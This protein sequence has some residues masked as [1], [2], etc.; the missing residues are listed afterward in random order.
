M[1]SLNKNQTFVYQNDET[2]N[3]LRSRNLLTLPSTAVSSAV[4][5]EGS[6]AY[7]PSLAEL[8][9]STGLAWVPISTQG[10]PL[11][12][13]SETVYVNKG[14]NDSTGDGTINAPFLTI[15]HALTTITDSSASKYYAIM[16]GPG[17]Y[18]GFNI[19]PYTAVIGTTGGAGNGTTPN[20]TMVTEINAPADTC[21]FDPSFATGELAIGWLAHLGF[22][23]HQTWDQGTVV[24][25]QPQLTFREI[26]WDAGASFLGPGTVG[27]DNVTWTNC[28]SYG[29]VLVQGWQ[30]LWLRDCTFLGGVVQVNAGPVGAL[31]QTTLL[32]ENTSFGAQISPTAVNVHWA[33]PSPYNAIADLC[34]SSIIGT[35]TLDG[36]Q[37]SFSSTVEGIPLTVSQINS[38]PPPVLKTSAFALGYTPTTPGNWNAP[39]PT[40]TQQALDRMASLLVTLNGGTPIP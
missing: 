24:G 36:V 15:Q 7:D 9:Y 6:I 10:P 26:S 32:A 37:T 13:F 29:G 1:S 21:G 5:P 17:I 16:V 25:A 28:L 31:E 39:E 4:G 20:G 18:G 40:T 22:M 33:S 11:P 27:F 2:F 38:A 14:G 35:L 8:I 3:Y 30:Y 23:N 12:T 34:N 19:K